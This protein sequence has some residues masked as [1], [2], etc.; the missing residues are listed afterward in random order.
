LRK[1]VTALKC[2]LSS[3]QSARLDCGAIFEDLGWNFDH[4][5]PAFKREELEREIQRAGLLERI[6]QPVCL[7]WCVSVCVYQVDNALAE[8]KL[9]VA[10]VK[11]CLVVGG[12]SRIPIVQQ[13]LREK[14]KEVHA[15]YSHTHTETHTHTNTHT[16]THECLESGFFWQPGPL[17]CH[18]CCPSRGNTR[19]T[20]ACA[21]VHRTTH[22]NA[23]HAHVHIR[24]LDVHSGTCAHRQTC[25]HEEE[26][27]SRYGSQ[28]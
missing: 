27:Q 26:L 23:Y 22:V 7:L 20:R 10:D 1:H 4:K 28:G 5:N 13:T 25:T 2:E 21:Q 8:A 17:C 9:E 6:M 18:G 16:H 12:S 14:F 19:Y 15:K 3:K 11:Q 24:A